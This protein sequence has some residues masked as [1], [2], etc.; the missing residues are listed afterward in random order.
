[1]AAM[2][3]K[4]PPARSCPS[5]L[6]QQVTLW[7]ARRLPAD[8]ANSAASIH[9]RTSRPV[10]GLLPGLGFSV[11]RPHFGRRLRRRPSGRNRFG[12]RLRQRFT[13]PSDR[14]RP[15]PGD[16][17]CLMPQLVGFAPGTRVRSGLWQLIQ[18]KKSL[19]K[20]GRYFS[21]PETYLVST[22]RKHS[23]QSG[24]KR[25]SSS[26]LSV[27]RNG[28]STRF[29]PTIGAHSAPSFTVTSIS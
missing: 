12:S 28:A 14:F 1:M 13:C 21:W 5:L 2:A 22:D 3:D 11:S 18:R 7:A 27:A 9:S 26:Y 29:A 15:R 20:T 23:I 17:W 8:S 25:E 4:T 6:R 10:R 19:V 24:S 16:R